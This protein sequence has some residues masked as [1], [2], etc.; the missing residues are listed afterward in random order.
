MSFFLLINT[1]F[2]PKFRKGEK[3]LLIKIIPN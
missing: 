1:P 2:K 3:K